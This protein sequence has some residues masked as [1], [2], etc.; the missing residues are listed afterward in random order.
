MRRVVGEDAHPNALGK[1]TH[2]PI[3]DRALELRIDLARGE[4]VGAAGEVDI[5]SLQIVGSNSESGKDRLGMLRHAVV[6]E[7]DGD[8]SVAQIG[9]FSKPGIG[10]NHEEVRADVHRRRNPQIDW[11]VER[12]LALFR[13]GNPWRRHEAEIDLARMQAI[14]VL[15]AHAQRRLHD[16]DSGHGRVALERGFQRE[17]LRVEGAAALP[18]PDPNGHSRLPR[19]RIV[20]GCMLNRR[21]ANW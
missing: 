16:L 9:D 19:R 5:D 2:H 17:P 13:G 10:A 18:G 14:G 4:H 7:A 11:T 8:L 12:R 1:V 15:D 3:G 6:L 20:A 21:L